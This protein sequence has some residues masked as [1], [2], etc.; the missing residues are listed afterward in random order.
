MTDLQ[1]QC[2]L[3]ALGYYP[4][5]E[6]DGIWGE[7]SRKGTRAFQESQGLEP[8]G[9]FDEKTRSAALKELEG[10]EE[11]R[12][13]N[14]IRYF[15]REEF[16]CRCGG[17]HCGG[18]PA[19]PVHTLVELADD[20][21]N[22]FGAPA[23]ITSGLRCGQHNASVGGVENSR[24]LTGKALDF[25]IQGVSGE[26]LLAAAQADARTRYAYIIGS[27]PHVHVDVS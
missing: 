18:F 11:K 12:F 17:K 22:R 8:T 23:H 9:V 6:I 19:E 10:G 24:H 3:A 1:A 16:R 21:R 15:T 26:A 7:K 13:W 4:H 5:R 25:Y 2:L 27:G 14:R 20:L